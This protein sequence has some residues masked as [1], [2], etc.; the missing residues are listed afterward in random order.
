MQS[1][2]KNRENELI[3]RTNPKSPVSEAFRSIRTNL[4]FL[5]PDSPIKT[6]LITSAGASEGKSLVLSNLAVSIAQNDNDVLIIDADLRRPMMHRFFEVTNYS[7]LSNILTEEISFDE[8]IMDTKID[9]L[10]IIGTGVIPPNPA[11]LLSSKKMKAVLKKA[12]EKAD[13]VLID[14][15]PVLAVTDAAVLSNKVDG[16]L[17]VVASHQ[18]QKEVLKRA[19]TTLK[20]AK[21]NIIG[22]ILNKYPLQGGSYYSGYYYDSYAEEE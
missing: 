3:T 2:I 12:K 22:S 15:P 11:E 19:H 20:R 4:S 18:T 14:S 17:M 6:I 5:S 1:N 16:V 21:A 8:A 10:K 9:R 7:G 13:I